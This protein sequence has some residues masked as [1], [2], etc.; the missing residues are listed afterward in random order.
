MRDVRFWESYLPNDGQTNSKSFWAI[1]KTKGEPLESSLEELPLR[2]S[3]SDGHIEEICP[4]TKETT[5]GL[6]IKRGVL[7][8]LQNTMRRLDL[9]HAAYEVIYL[10]I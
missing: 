9:E 7:S 2:F 8:A 6:N 5:L 10:K 3:Y 4:E 1:E